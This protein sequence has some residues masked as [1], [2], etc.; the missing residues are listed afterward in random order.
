MNP[1]TLIKSFDLSGSRALVTG[2]SSGLGRH[3]AS[4]L[5]GAGAEVVL[6]ARRED[7]L[8]QAVEDIAAQGGRAHAVAI[9]VR[10]RASVCRALDAAATVSGGP[11]DVLVNNAGIAGTKP[12]LE[13]TDQ[14]WDA[15]VGT[16]L[17][18]AWI[19]AQEASRRMV[20]AAQS[21][22]IINVTSVL[23]N[24]VAGGVSPY[25]ASKAGLKH[26]TQALA[27]ELARHGIRVNSLAPGYVITD[28]NQDFLNGRS[29]EKLRDR[30]PMRRF[31]SLNDLDGPLLLL[32]SRAG[33]Y[34]TGA[35]IV[36]D[37]G[38]QC[39]SL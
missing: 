24:R 13:Y 26:L 23:A 21:G 33:A 6:T 22:S 14:D 27:L 17:M 28:L 39:N 11:I 36:V 7:Q 19:V 37:G 4:V 18:G 5:A 31:G 20:N 32:A 8:K 12:P 15:I 30:N 38:H 34:I 35:E 1:A 9:D 3:F 16:N 29:G 2:A 25:C 10:Q